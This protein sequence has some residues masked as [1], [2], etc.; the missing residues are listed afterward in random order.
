[1]RTSS[2]L[3][4]VWML[5]LTAA[6][7]CLAPARAD[8][9]SSFHPSGGGFAVSMPGS[10]THQHQSTT[11]N[12]MQVESDL[13][14]LKSGAE[15]YF[16]GVTVYGVHVDV[17]AEI[18][19]DRDN[20]DKAVGA[21]PTSQ[22]YISSNGIAGFDVVSESGDHRFHALWFSDGRRAWGAVFAM[23]TASF[24]SDL[25]SRF[26]NSFQLTSADT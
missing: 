8:Y 5:A 4:I 17:P 23:P 6:V 10:P 26:L 19:L 18:A 1:V 16:V 25:A 21:T 13:Y 14:G 11:M 20:F 15:Y 22:R 24:D 9:W 12:G 7:G 3:A 2:R